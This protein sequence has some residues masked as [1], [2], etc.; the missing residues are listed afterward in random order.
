MDVRN[1][2]LETGTIIR[3]KKL[4]K[5]FM[6]LPDVAIEVD[7]S[8]WCEMDKMFGSQ[9]QDHIVS[10]YY[11]TLL[12]MKTFKAEKKNLLLDRYELGKQLHEKEK[13]VFLQR[14]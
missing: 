13:D 7:V 5:D 12:D 9:M 2:R 3:D 10:L 1:I 14:C 8:E 11:Q 6:L 4:K